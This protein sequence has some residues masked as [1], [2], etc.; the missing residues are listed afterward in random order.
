[1]GQTKKKKEDALE[2]KAQAEAEGVEGN[3]K[4]LAAKALL[5]KAEHRVSEAV[6][7]LARARRDEARS[8]ERQAASV[9][10]ARRELADLEESNARRVLDAERR[11]ADA[12]EAG[13]DSAVAAADNIR[14]AQ[15]GLADANDRLGEA[16][17]NMA[18]ATSRAAKL[19]EEAYE[20]MTA[21]GRAFLDYLFAMKERF[22]EV[23]RVM[24]DSML[25]GFLQALKNLEPLYDPSLK[26]FGAM[27]KVMGDLA[28]AA[29]EAVKSPFWVQFGTM[30]GERLPVAA[31][32]FGRAI[33]NVVTGLAGMLNAVWPMGEGFNQSFLSMTESF[34]KWFLEPV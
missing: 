15:Q 31:D 1:L 16:Q 26:F 13:A 34:A 3:S 14:A 22:S 9:A 25:G 30:L 29:S 24:Q 6:E 11:L 28:V 8:A 7:S 2:E 27:G 20:G 33:G 21:T 23:S 17:T 10:K 12:R 32:T 19:T 4:V 5:E 18:G